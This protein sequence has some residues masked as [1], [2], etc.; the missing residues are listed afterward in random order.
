MRTSLGQAIF[1][2]T[3]SRIFD[4]HLSNW[5][6]GTPRSWSASRLREFYLQKLPRT[7]FS[8]ALAAPL[9]YRWHMGLERLLPTRPKM[10]QISLET[11]NVPV[12]SNE[13]LDIDEAQSVGIVPERPHSAI[14]WF[15]V[16][17]KW[18]IDITIGIFWK[19]VVAVLL[20]R[21]AYT[22]R[23]SEVVS[24]MSLVSVSLPATIK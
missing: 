20:E 24:P 12:G 18:T 19:S 21:I 23:P 13:K 2:A 9:R 1:F 15:N 22:S 8:V 14:S 17:V 7:L 16:L 3:L 5:A 4:F 6:V 10:H 11:Y